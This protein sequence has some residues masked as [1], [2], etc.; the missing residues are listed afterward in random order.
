MKT[1]KQP[2]EVFKSL[3]AAARYAGLSRVTFSRDVLP[4]VPHRRAGRRILITRV[5][6]QRWLEGHDEEAA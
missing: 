3:N 1:Q 6:L 2:E 4:N 5:A